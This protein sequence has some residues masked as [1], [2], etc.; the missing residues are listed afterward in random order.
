MAASINNFNEVALPDKALILGEMR[1]LGPDS[2]KEHQKII[3]MLE[4]F[5]LTDVRLVGHCFDNA[6]TSFPRYADVD[7]LIADVK[8]NPIEG[9]TI[10]VKGSNGNHLDRVVEWL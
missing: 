7:A 6:R 1:E 3:D 5:G 2:D 8:A 10:L 4:N 9:K